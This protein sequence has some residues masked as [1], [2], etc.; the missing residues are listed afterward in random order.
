MLEVS[1]T[2]QRKLL[3]G[4]DPPWF[5]SVSPTAPSSQELL[6]K[7]YLNRR[8]SKLTLRRE[9]LG[10]LF[11]HA[12]QNKLNKIWIP[13]SS[14]DS[15]SQNFQRSHDICLTRTLCDFY[16]Q[17]SWEIEQCEIKL[18]ASQKVSSYHFKVSIIW[19]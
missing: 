17:A 19:P 16:D 10:R 9:T 6:N 12:L 8:G 15:P 4:K 7:W 1:F 3:K 2:Y 13:G 18:G 11:K 14:P 5:F